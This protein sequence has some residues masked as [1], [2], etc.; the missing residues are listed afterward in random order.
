MINDYVDVHPP[1]ASKEIKARKKST[2]LKQNLDAK[3]ESKCVIFWKK[4]CP[5]L[6]KK[7]QR[8]R[9]AKRA[10]ALFCLCMYCFDVGSD[11]RVG[12]DLFNRC[13]HLTGKIL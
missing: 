3:T 8:A 1:D 5:C 6:S 7:K 9:Q 12:F 2:D 11:L 10:I 4:C 13:H